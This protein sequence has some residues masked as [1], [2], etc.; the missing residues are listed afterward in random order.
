MCLITRTI[1]MG[2]KKKTKDAP[3][4]TVAD[5]KLNEYVAR[6]SRMLQCRTVSDEDNVDESEFE[7]FRAVLREEFPLLHEKGELLT[8]DGAL[9][10]RVKGASDR[11]IILMSHHDVVNEH[12]DW[13]YPAFGA[14]IHDGK[15]YAR[16]TLDTKTPLFIKIVYY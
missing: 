7:K 13:D 2:N 3:N 12:G 10:F 9:V 6:L 5:E 11:N 8:F 4:M 16:G 15:I 1:L 14:E